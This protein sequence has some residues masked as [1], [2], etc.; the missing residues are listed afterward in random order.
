MSKADDGTKK[1]K[2]DCVTATGGKSRKP[3]QP[4]KPK[5]KRGRM[6]ALMQ[7]RYDAPFYGET[8][9]SRKRTGGVLQCDHLAYYYSEEDEVAL[10]GNH[11]RGQQ[12]LK[13]RVNP[14]AAAKKVQDQEAR[15]KQIESLAQVNREAG[16][17]GK[18]TLQRM[19]MVRNPTFTVGVKLVFPNYK[20]QARTDG[21]G[22][23]SL[24]PK[25]MGPVHHGQPGLP[26]ALNLEN[27]HQGVSVLCMY[28]YV[29]VG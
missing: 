4:K 27:M 6:S 25:S 13:L 3:K 15:N 2:A 12:A 26:I 19:M 14:D 22:C 24:S 29:C 9:C 20:H 17:R 1:R 23:S 28:V 10:C 7:E 18:L 11:C 8:T 21:F 16:S 5:L